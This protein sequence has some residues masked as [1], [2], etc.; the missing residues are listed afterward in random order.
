MNFISL[1]IMSNLDLRN[2]SLK[3]SHVLFIKDLYTESKN[4]STEKKVSNAGDFAS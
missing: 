3:S 1:V 2:S 4:R